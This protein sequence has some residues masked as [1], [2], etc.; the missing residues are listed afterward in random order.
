MCGW[1]RCV[2]PIPVRGFR[3]KEQRMHESS[4]RGWCRRPLA[5]VRCEIDVDD[6]AHEI[7]LSDVRPRET[8]G[9]GSKEWKKNGTRISKHRSKGR[10]TW[11]RTPRVPDPD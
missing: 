11:P 9:N 2:L 1:V 4:E 8:S 10:E 6:L 7:V 3:C 5:L